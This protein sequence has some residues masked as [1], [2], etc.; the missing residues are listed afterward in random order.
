MA[1][2]ITSYLPLVTFPLLYAGAWFWKRTRPVSASDMDFFTGI[3]EIEA[4]TYDEPPPKNRVE[5]FWQWLVSDRVESF[6]YASAHH[7]LHR[8]EKTLSTF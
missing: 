4:K 8:C 5:A 7:L 3:A 6:L 1:D 2:F